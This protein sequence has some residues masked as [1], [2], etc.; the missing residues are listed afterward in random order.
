MSNVRGGDNLQEVKEF[1]AKKFPNL[2]GDNIGVSHI[3]DLKKVDGHLDP[4]RNLDILDKN[5]EQAKTE[6]GHIYGG[7]VV[8]QTQRY[9]IQQKGT[10]HNFIAHLRDKMPKNP[11]LDGYSRIKYI[12]GIGVIEDRRAMTKSLGH[13]IG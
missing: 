7:V 8:G 10:S 9:N 1:I 2:V 3:T 13:G 4:Q 5:I 6:N 11:A 12:N